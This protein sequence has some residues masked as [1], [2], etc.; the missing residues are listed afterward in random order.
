M[1]EQIA[2]HELE[3]SMTYE[4]L[5]VCPYLSFQYASETVPLKILYAANSAGHSLN[6]YLHRGVEGRVVQSQTGTYPKVALSRLS[7]G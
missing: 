6:C 5:D 2:N 3:H 7:N 4:R 1:K